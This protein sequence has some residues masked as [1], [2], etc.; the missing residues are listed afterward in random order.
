MKGVDWL[1]ERILFGS[2]IIIGYIA[3]VVVGTARADNLPPAGAA[4]LHDA[5][6]ALGPLAGMVIQSVF[7]TDKTD[8]ESAAAISTLATAVASQPPSSI[9]GPLANKET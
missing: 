6:L 1:P 4:L 7:K 8:K 3:V 5:M 9:T 2:M